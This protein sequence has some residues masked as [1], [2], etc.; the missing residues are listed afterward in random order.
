MFT[1]CFCASG[2][3][4][5]QGRNVVILSLTR[6]ISLGLPTPQP[7]SSNRNLFHASDSQPAD[8]LARRAAG[9]YFL[10]PVSSGVFR[11]EGIG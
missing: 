1:I 2:S 7:N 4:S 5:V 3:I 6:P 10:A 9:C 8:D 11:V